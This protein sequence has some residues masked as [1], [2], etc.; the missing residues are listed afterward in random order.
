MKNNNVLIVVAH[1]DDETIG[2]GG[3]IKKHTIKGDK[4]FVVSMTNGVGARDSCNKLKVEERINCAENASKILGFN[5]I[6]KYDFKDNSLDS[7]SILEI[8]K[9]IE[10]IKS[11]IRP[12]LVYTHS[13]A[14][15]NVDHRV[16][17][18]SVFT[19]FRPQ[20][21]E[22]CQ[23]I[24]LFE[25]ASATDFSHQTI[26]SVFSPNLYINIDKTWKYKSLAL[27]GYGNE[28]KNY[29]HSRSLEG[30]HNLAK[31]RGNQV[32]IMMAEAFQVAR[33]IE[34]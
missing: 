29:P 28:I 14:D 24:R 25:T 26:T 3:T 1:P 11:K 15:L 8:T 17:S 33:K 21:D 19:A 30:L 32:G 5:W 7:Y 18:N 10:K 12:Y 13:G 34:S 16:I 6:E 2:M 27:D 31:V 23:E 9:S 22:I 4:V 20:P